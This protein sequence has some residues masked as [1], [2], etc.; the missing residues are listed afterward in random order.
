MTVRSPGAVNDAVMATL[1]PTGTEPGLTFADETHW[2]AAS[3]GGCGRPSA[4]GS[5]VAVIT[6]TAAKPHDDRELRKS[7][8]AIFS[9]SRLAR[10]RTVTLNPRARSVPSPQPS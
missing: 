1:P 10:Q 7:R 2:L 9:S 4:G 6:A 5:S 3:A 8:L